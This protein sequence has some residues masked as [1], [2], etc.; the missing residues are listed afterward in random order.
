ML[1]FP[2]LN[3]TFDTYTIQEFDLRNTP[4]IEESVRHSDVVFNLIGRQYT[5]K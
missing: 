2:E 1:Q 4:S 3:A 5:T